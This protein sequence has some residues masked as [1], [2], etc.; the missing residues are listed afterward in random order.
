ML[1]NHLDVT[2][3][4]SPVIDD[5]VILRIHNKCGSCLIDVVAAL[6]CRCDI[7]DALLASHPANDHFFNDLARCLRV[8]MHPIGTLGLYE[9]VAAV[10]EFRNVSAEIFNQ[11]KLSAR[12][13]SFIA[14]CIK[15]QIV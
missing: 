3:P 13:L 11:G 9:S 4:V 12:V 2:E 1:A 15:D 5:S 6:N 14:V 7:L 10:V 8:S